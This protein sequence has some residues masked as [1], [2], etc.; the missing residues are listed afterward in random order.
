MAKVLIRRAIEQ[1]A[2]A[3]NANYSVPGQS[4]PYLFNYQYLGYNFAVILSAVEELYLEYGVPML[5]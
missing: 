5:L 1:G 4:D 2:P 3:Y